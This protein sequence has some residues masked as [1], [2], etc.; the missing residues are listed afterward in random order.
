MDRRY[1]E[2]AIAAL[3]ALDIDLD[4]NIPLRKSKYDGTGSAK[5]Q[6]WLAA[7]KRIA[8]IEKSYRAQLAA[9][10]TP[11]QEAA[12]EAETADVMDKTCGPTAFHKSRKGSE[13]TNCVKCGYPLKP[14]YGF[15]F[16]GVAP[17]CDMC[18]GRQ[19]YYGAPVPVKESLTAEPWEALEAARLALVEIREYEDDAIDKKTA[20]M[21]RAALA[22][23]A[24]A[25]KG[26]Q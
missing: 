7:Q 8:I 23:I 17:L 19:R 6:G 4:D 11:E 14:G 5:E 25:Q 22:K 24:A 3:G 21:I 12:M 20:T 9:L 16:D 26:K 13:A 15:E 18:C 2:G 10:P 1:L